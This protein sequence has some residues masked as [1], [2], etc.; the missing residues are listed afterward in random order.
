MPSAIR[1][2]D[3]QS[4]ETV[5]DI[6]ARTTIN[7]I[8]YAVLSTDA[9]AFM[10]MFTLIHAFLLMGIN[11][12]KLSTD[13]ARIT[14]AIGNGPDAQYGTQIMGFADLLKNLYQ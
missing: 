11:C 9:E 6:R 12:N 14:Y 7:L 1:H 3:R 5:S 13:Y 4:V 8:Y 2:R 10:S